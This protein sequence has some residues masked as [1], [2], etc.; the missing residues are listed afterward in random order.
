MNRKKRQDRKQRKG[1]AERMKH[2][3]EQEELRE[4]EVNT[5]EASDMEEPVHE[6][7]VEPSPD[8]VEKL[9]TE[10]AEHYDKY[11]RTYAE[12]ENYRKRMAREKTDLLQYGNE[13]LIKALLPVLDSIGRALEHAGTSEDLP[14]FIEGIRLVE[15]QFL[16]ALE[17]HGVKPIEAKGEPFDPN[18]HEALY[19]V[20]TPDGESGRVVDEL[21]KGYL[22][23]GRLL[24]PSKV[25]VSKGAS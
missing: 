5:A 20:K 19:E 7:A 10:A 23:N 17:N 12:Y 8:D 16:Q 14:S 24:R 2:R 25:S 18:F 9:R 6:A 1:T 3:E 4:K 11:L 15:K 22:L 21:E 13:N